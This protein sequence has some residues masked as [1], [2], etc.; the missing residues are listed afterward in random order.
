MRRRRGTPAL[1]TGR[2]VRRFAGWRRGKALSVVT[3]LMAR[4]LVVALFSR[5]PDGAARRAAA[6]RR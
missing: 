3:A 5:V 4:A 6:R 1:Q 2:F